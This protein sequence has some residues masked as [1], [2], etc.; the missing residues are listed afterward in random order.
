[1]PSTQDGLRLEDLAACRDF[2]GSILGTGIER[3][4]VGDII[5]LGETGAQILV[6]AEL[7]EHF[8]QSLTQV[9]LSQSLAMR[10][11]APCKLFLQ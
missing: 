9:G 11:N 1:M 4:K 10:S 8:E 5:I 6:A 3:G 2:L 7:V